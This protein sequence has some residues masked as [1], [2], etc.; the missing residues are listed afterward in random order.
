MF[1]IVEK[2]NE[3]KTKREAL[4]EQVGDYKGMIL[5]NDRRVKQLE[6][7]MALAN[8]LIEQSHG[9]IMTLLQNTVTSA[10]LDI[11]GEGHAFHLDFNKKGKTIVC[12]FR[13]E[14]PRYGGD[15]PLEMSHGTAI[16]S[17]I[18]VVLRIVLVS[19]MDCINLVILDEPF[20]GI[21]H[22]KETVA[23]EFLNRI[24]KEFDVQVVMVTHR[25][26]IYNEADKVVRL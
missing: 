7:N 9:K 13:L 10:L 15:T 4:F 11:F 26:A 1:N 20:E 3:L 6:K 8:V 21:Q 5:G 14:S 25:E 17:V 22:E 12:K 16:R 23:G 19:L 2:F 24:C 18:A